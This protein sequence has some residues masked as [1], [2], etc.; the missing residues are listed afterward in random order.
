MTAKGLMMKRSNSRGFTLI[1]MAMVLLIMGLLLGGGLAVLSSQIENQKTKET[2]KILEE[3]KEALIGFAIANGRLPCPASAT[4]AGQES[5]CTNATPAA[6]GAA[7][8]FPA[9]PPTHGRCT[10]PNNG[11]LAAATLGFTPVDAVGYAID[12]WNISQNRLHYA[13][14]TANTSAFTKPGGMKETT[15]GT[16]ASD[17]HVC[18]TATGT[19]TTSCGTATKLTTNATAVIYSVGKNATTGGTSTDEAANPNPN[20]ANEDQVFISRPPSALG[21][22]IGEF[23]DIVIWLSPNVLFNRMVQA[24]RLP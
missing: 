7:I 22:P 13:V 16:L 1:E 9:A 5:F 17:L 14:T 20:S 23:D 19:T 8:I 3:A 10:N 21:S 6:C 18:T 2:Q 24:G 12:A 4:S 11:F 15:L